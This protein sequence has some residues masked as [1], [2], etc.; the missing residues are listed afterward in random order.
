MHVKEAAV[1]TKTKN[2]KQKQNKLSNK[3]A[4]SGEVFVGTNASSRRKSY[5]LAPD[6]ASGT[7]WLA[8]LVRLKHRLSFSLEAQFFLEIYAPGQEGCRTVA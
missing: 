5:K 1:K 8:A 6:K 2:S 7:R 3:G 4:V